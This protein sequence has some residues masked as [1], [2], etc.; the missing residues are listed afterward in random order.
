MTQTHKNGALRIAVDIGGTFTDMAAFD[1]ASGQLLF[2]KALL[3]KCAWGIIP[4]AVLIALA[5]R[6][7]GAH[8]IFIERSSH[9]RKHAGQIAFPGGRMDPGD[10]DPVATALREAHEEI[11]LPPQAVTPLGFLDPYQTGSGY[12]I[13]PLVAWLRGEAGVGA[14]PAGGPR[15]SA[16]E[17]TL[18]ALA[19]LFRCFSTRRICV[20]PPMQRMPD[21][22]RASDCVSGVHFEARHSMWPRK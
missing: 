18:P 20:C 17:V 14:M 2:G 13:A 16:P 10:A 11:A 22:S 1:E 6:E 21:M 5:P 15:L 4:A 19:S 12:R 7:E 8:L 9:L 3:V